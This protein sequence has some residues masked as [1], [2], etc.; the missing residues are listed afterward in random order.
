LPKGL[1]S[2]GIPPPDELPLA[3]LDEVPLDAPLDEAPLDAPLDDAPELA[4]LEE[5]APASPDEAPELVP[6]DAPEDAP[7]DPLPLEVVA[8][9]PLE[10]VP[11]DEPFE[12]EELPPEAFDPS[13]VPS[14]EPPSF[15][16]ACVPLLPPHAAAATNAAS[17]ATRTKVDLLNSSI[18][19]APSAPPGVEWMKPS[20]PTNSGT[21]G[22]AL[23]TGSFASHWQPQLPVVAGGRTSPCR[24]TP[25]HPS[26]ILLHMS[27]RI[28]S[29]RRS[30][31]VMSLAAPHA[32]SNQGA[33]AHA[34]GATGGRPE[35]F[36]GKAVE[37]GR[38]HAPPRRH[39]LR[40]E[41]P[42]AAAK[43]CAVDLPRRLAS[44]V[45]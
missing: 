30:V 10:D 43:G 4:P 14:V 25:A 2:A 15:S 37:R 7:L 40:L 23:T 31:R 36:S 41:R 26:S 45:P 24:L 29:R 42:P 34:E 17:A 39:R 9:P 28:R 32:A 12:P 21:L 11:D 6:D 19:V 13:V 33:R 5:S 1:A 18:M 3:P 20:T 35:R 44:P 27:R 16:P 22:G 8:S 38:I